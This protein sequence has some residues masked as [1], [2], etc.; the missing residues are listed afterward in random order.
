MKI[1][2]KVILRDIVSW[3]QTWEMIPDIL[4]PDLANWGGFAG[5][6][7]VCQCCNFLHES[8]KSPYHLTI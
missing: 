4:V 7:N 3:W 2:S 1:F 5:E 8:L 6:S